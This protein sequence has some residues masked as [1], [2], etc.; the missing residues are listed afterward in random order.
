MMDRPLTVAGLFAHGRTVHRDSVV[1]TIDVDLGQ[2]I[3]RTFAETADRVDR[4]AATLRDLNVGRGDRVA[5]LQANTAS[6][7]ECYLAIPAMGA[8][9]HTLNCRLSADQLVHCINEAGDSVIIVDA[10]YLNLLDDVLSYAPSVTTV[11][12]T[13]RGASAAST[14]AAA[15]QVTALTFE[16]AIAQPREPISYPADLDELECAGI[17][18]SSGTTGDPKGVAYSHRSTWLHA[19]T[20]TTANASGIGY[21]D[22]VMPIVPMFHANAWGYPYAAWLAGAD[23]AFPGPDLSAPALAAFIAHARPT[24]SAG[25]PVV[26]SDLLRWGENHDLDL[27]SFRMLLC[28][29]SAVPEQL[30]RD[31]EERHGLRIVQGWGMTETSP[32]AAVTHPPKTVVPG[33]AEEW[34]YRLSAGRILFG[35]EARIVADDGQILPS[36]GVHVGELEVRGPWVTGS[37]L[38]GQSPEKFEDG[39]LRTGDVGALSP[40][41]YIRLTDRAKDVIKSGGEWIS[42]V[43]LENHLAGHPAVDDAVVIGVGDDRW[44]ERPLACVVL[45]EGAESTASDLRA[46]LT[47][48]VPR[49]WLPERWAFTDAVPRTSV[50]KY[51][52]VKLRADLAAGRISPQY[53]AAEAR[54]SV[55]P[56]EETAE[57]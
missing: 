3:T 26:W 9:L 17:C 35:V 12:V 43:E 47:D 51:D 36:D 49:W 14:L 8:V 7:L 6:H 16:S 54:P 18:H 57:P 25:V 22:V 44:G 38:G 2:P 45:R 32:V 50:G 1:T 46:F 11:L 42:S 41:G 55:Q 20:A 5:T 23:L 37:Y 31:Y 15:T 28:G 52:K 56:H 48:R 33:S 29:G 4:L 24:I 10:T 30:M 40:D 34:M 13:G 27:S 53:V 39:W 19:L 21:R